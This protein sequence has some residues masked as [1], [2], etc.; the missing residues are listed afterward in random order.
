M[1][2]PIIIIA[3]INNF[4]FRY[5]SRSFNDYLGDQIPIPTRTMNQKADRKDQSACAP[6][7]VILRIPVYV[8]ILKQL[9]ASGKT[10]ISSNG[11][12]KLLQI[13]PAQIRK[14]LSYFGKFGKQGRGYNIEYLLTALNKILGIDQEWKACLVGV[15]RLGRAIINYPGFSPHGFEIVACFDIDKSRINE[16]IAGMSIQPLDQIKNLVRS[17]NIKIG[18]VSVPADQTQ[19]VV[20]LLVAA[21]V[22]G[23]LNYAPISPVVETDIIVRT[24]DPVTSMQSMTYYLKDY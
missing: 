21:G 22:K 23:I 19:S 4:T 16:P 11:L 14:D 9:K 5:T 3:L 12:G 6:E 13:T 20:D 18:I 15:G 10:V 17:N 2:N 7:V 24:I 1:N 8:R